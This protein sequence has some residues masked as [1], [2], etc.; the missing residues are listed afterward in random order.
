M[1]RHLLRALAILAVLASALNAQ[2]VVTGEIAGTITDPSGA[3]VSNARV[4]LKSDA[5]GATQSA[6][7]GTAGDFHFSLLRPGAYTLTIIAAGFEQTIQ[8]ATVSLAQVTAIRIQ[9]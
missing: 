9:L 1:R 4:V 2:T 7:T 8:Q 3:S 6:T 5:N